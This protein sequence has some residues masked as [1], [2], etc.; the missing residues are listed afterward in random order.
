[1]GITQPAGYDLINKY[2]SGVDPSEI[3]VKNTG[4][5]WYFKRYLFQ[6][7]VSVF[8]FSG[9]P[10]TWP[11]NYLQY[12]L[13]LWGYVGIINTRPFGVIP[14][15]GTLSGRNVFYLP[16]IFVFNNPKIQGFNRPIIGRQCEIIKMQPDYGSAWDIVSFYG[17]MLALCAEAAGVNLLNSKLAYVFAAG[18]KQAAESFKK[19][20]DQIASGKPAAFYDSSLNDPDGA[21]AWQAFNQNLKQTYIAGDVLEDMAK[22]DSRFNTEIG[23][24]NVNIAKASGVSDSEINANNIDTNAKAALWLETINDDLIKVNKMFN[25]NITCKLRFSAAEG[26]LN[27]GLIVDNGNV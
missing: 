11:K 25:L 15:W 19:L 26:G 10:E 21:P 27:N 6:K 7:V 3:H 1:M 9:L 14:Q 4:L 18:N 8:E 23:I 13:F 5:S 20:Y 17:D 22:W 24:P 12:V 16:N 2:N